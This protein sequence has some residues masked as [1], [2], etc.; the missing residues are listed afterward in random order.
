LEK[1]KEISINLT[2]KKNLEKGF[3]DIFCD[4]FFLYEHFCDYIKANLDNHRKNIEISKRILHL[5]KPQD[6]FPE[7]RKLKRKI[8]YHFGPTNSGKTSNAIKRLSE[9][10][11]GIYCA[12]LRL[13]AWEIYEKMNKMGVNC[14]L[15]TGQDKFFKP[16]STHISLTIEKADYRNYYDVAVI[17]EIQM[18]E[19]EE[20]G[21][22]WTNALL[23]I[24]SKEIHLCGDERALYL[25]KQLCKETGDE[26]YYKSYSRFSNLIVENYCFEYSEL[27]PGDCIISF[28]KFN[29]M[30]IK[31]K[32][33]N[34][35][36]QNRDVV[37][38]IY[39]DLPSETKK[40][41]AMMF[42]ETTYSPHFNEMI[43]YDFLVA[44]DAVKF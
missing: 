2:T 8:I 41:Q 6:Y 7:A 9:A 24:N 29:I 14:N 26:L 31:R 30:D 43:K 27:M 32:I 3:I 40:D 44:S 18:I 19:D 4:Y 21:S 15:S 42:N 34:I 12:P 33:L 28:N 5:N 39:G 36:R 22:A 16:N 23:G 38:I 37:G 17:D 20:R 25:I 10:K 35:T 13:L 11:T 1:L